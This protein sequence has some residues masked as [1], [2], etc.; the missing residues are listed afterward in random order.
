MSNLLHADFKRLFKSKFFWLSS[1]VMLAMGVI[2]PIDHF[3][4]NKEA[5]AAGYPEDVVAL[6]EGFFN[7]VIAQFIMI[8]IMTALFVGLD[9]ANGTIRNKI[10]VG[11]KR[12]AIYLSNLITLVTAVAIWSVIYIAAACAVGIPLLGMFKSG[13]WNIVSLMLLSFAMICA[14]TAILLVVTMLC[15]NR[16]YSAIICLLMVFALLMTGVIINSMLEE[17]EM[18]DAYQV[19]NT[20]TGEMLYDEGGPNPNYV[21]GTKRQVLQEMM[22]ILPGGQ[23]IRICEVNT[24]ELEIKATYD[25][26][27]FVLLSGVGIVF[28]KRKDLK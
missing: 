9:Y 13:L 7:Y 1:L 28:W 12:G 19:M 17:P 25:L 14:L 6:D 26:L 16:T 23:L 24:E 5:I 27:I 18:Y 15:Q 2:L 21:S 3:F 22:N 4:Y 8:S 20:E 10:V 11:K